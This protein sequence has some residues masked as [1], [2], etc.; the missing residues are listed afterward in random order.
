MWI[1]LMSLMESNMPERVLMAPPIAFV[2][3]S[4]E[5]ASPPD[6]EFSK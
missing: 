5:I 6:L 1:S 2:S 3:V 4:L